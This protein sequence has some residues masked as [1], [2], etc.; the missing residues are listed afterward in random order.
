MTI[1]EKLAARQQQQSE[2]KDDANMNW[3]DRALFKMLVII[4]T[5][6]AIGTVIA[7]LIERLK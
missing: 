2:K 4:F 3:L 6:Y 5:G 1:R 7:L